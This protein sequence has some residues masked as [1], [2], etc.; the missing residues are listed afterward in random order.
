MK[1]M[2]FVAVLLL[3]LFCKWPTSVF[4]ADSSWLKLSLWGD[5]AAAASHNNLNYVHGLDLGIGSTTDHICGVQLDIA[6][7]RVN[8]EFY[9]VQ[10]SWIY[11][12]APEFSGVQSSLIDVADQF[13]GVQWGGLNLANRD[14]TGVQLGFVNV[15]LNDFTGVQFSFV[16]YTEKFTGVQAGF[17]NVAKD[18]NGLQLGL[19]NYTENVYGLQIGLVNVA[20][21]NWL[22]AMILVNGRF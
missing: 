9:G 4:A 8:N 17:V 3:G 13:T 10:T 7:S 6:Y 15:D 19:V 21:K 14:F 20:T 5:I 2:L 11:A 12:S 16:N 22:P 18:V 1:K